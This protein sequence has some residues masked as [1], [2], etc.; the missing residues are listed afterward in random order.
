VDYSPPLSV[1]A[2]LLALQA[3]YLA[4]VG[5]L[6]NRF[7][8]SSQVGLWRQVAF[9]QGVLV[10]LLALATPLETLAD[11]YLFSAHMLQH[12]LVTL[13]AAPLLLAGTPGWLMRDLLGA[14]G[15]NVLRHLRHPILAFGV[16]NLVFALSHVP[17]LY[18]LFL[19]TPPLHAL[20]HLIFL[21]TAILM[22]MPVLSPLPEVPRYP[23]LGQVLYL[24]L[25]SVPAS[26]VGALLS[27]A[28]SAYY[29]TYVTAPR[30]LGLTPLEDQQ[31]GGLMMWVGSGL[32][33]LLAMGV[34]FFVWASRE[35]AENRRPIGV[36]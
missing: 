9:A 3:L 28:G 30:V 25:Q 29:A 26:L 12:L 32:Y 31:V 27:G 8:G 11:Q 10:L 6:R 24:F 20:E 35:E 13:V 7:R 34:V 19:A 33:F 4:C 16:F 36:H 5:P 1:L 21:A 17:A 23:D 2:G 18:E 22:W 14:G 15:I